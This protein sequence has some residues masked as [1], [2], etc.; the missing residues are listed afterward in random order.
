M[1]SHRAHEYVAA[2]NLHHEY[3]AAFNPHSYILTIHAYPLHQAHSLTYAYTYSVLD[4]LLVHWL[5]QC[6]RCLQNT[7]S[8]K[9]PRVKAQNRQL[10]EDLLL[11][12]SPFFER[13]ML[14]WRLIE[15][16]N[17]PKIELEQENFGQL[18]A[19]G[20]VGLRAG[21]GSRRRQACLSR[22]QARARPQ[23]QSNKAGGS[24]DG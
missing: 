20:P 23:E 16:S 4:S 13:K 6:A 3:G 9:R 22:R 2:F 5:L 15:K 21:F 24:P 18:D 10:L 8:R 14:P 11:Q 1:K 17:A 7:V 12:N 19:E